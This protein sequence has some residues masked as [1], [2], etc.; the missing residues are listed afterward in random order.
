MTDGCQALGLAQRNVR[1]RPTGRF[2]MT[3]PANERDKTA[4][5]GTARSRAGRRALARYAGQEAAGAGFS[6]AS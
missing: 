6:A 5:I 1:A 3:R 2:L 4:R